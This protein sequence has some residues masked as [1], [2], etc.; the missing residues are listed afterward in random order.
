MQQII[1]FHVCFPEKKFQ[2][3]ILTVSII[4][5][6]WNGIWYGNFE[7]WYEYEGGSVPFF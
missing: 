4:V 7:R 5:L 2:I 6:S 3:S 1:L